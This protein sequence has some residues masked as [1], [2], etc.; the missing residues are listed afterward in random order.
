MTAPIPRLLLPSS[1]TVKVRIADGGMGGHY[2]EPVELRHVRFEPEDDAE[3]LSWQLRNG[4]KG[5]LFVDAVNTEGA[6]AIPAGSLVSVDGAPEAAVT[7]CEEL[8]DFGRVHH[9]EVHIG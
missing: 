9:W 2:E 4:A 6:F 3:N 7:S 5:T 1:A 8:R